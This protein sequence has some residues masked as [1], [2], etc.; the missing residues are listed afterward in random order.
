MGAKLFSP[1]E[2]REL[3]D[4]CQKDMRASNMAVFY[5]EGN[6]QQRGGLVELG[7]SIMAGLPTYIIGDCPSFEPVSHSDAA[8]MHHPLVHR[9]HAEQFDNGSYDV[10][11]GYTNAVRHYLTYYH[12]PEKVFMETNFLHA[13]PARRVR[14]FH[15]PSTLMEASVL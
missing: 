6:E 13:Y 14:G 3:W 9:V 12:T 1:S 5:G 7:M 4:R 8:Y 11:E 15:D 2:K 10:L